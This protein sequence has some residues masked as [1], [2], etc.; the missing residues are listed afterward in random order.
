M[1]ALPER[2]PPAGP[3]V[4][5]DGRR[6]PRRAARW[7]SLVC[8]AILC[9]TLL[10]S[11]APASAGFQ[12]LTT[13]ENDTIAGDMVVL[14]LKESI[15]PPLADELR[16]IASSLSPETRR[17]L[18]DLDSP[19]GSL[20]ETEKIVA[21]I[22]RMRASRRVDTLVR[23]GAM[24]ASACVALFMQ[25]EQRIAGGSSVW[26]FHGVCYAHTNVPSLSLTDRFIDILREAGADEDFLCHLVDEGYVTAAGKLWL[27]GYELVNVYHANIITELL[28]P[29]RPEPPYSWPAVPMGPR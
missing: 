8:A 9:G 15:V 3:S 18:F 24:C 23:H 26:L 10:V 28:E 21:V 22:A 29:W 16:T 27:S 14:R 12:V 7:A 11:A 20:T 13:K 17:V 4:H 2:E 25:G 6:A 19:G 5:A 1:F